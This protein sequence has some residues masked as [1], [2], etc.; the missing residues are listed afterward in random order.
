MLIQGDIDHVF[1]VK[2]IIF[3]FF[4]LVSLDIRLG[5]RSPNCT[6]THHYNP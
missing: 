3:H 4:V 5:D 1:V 6:L 2:L